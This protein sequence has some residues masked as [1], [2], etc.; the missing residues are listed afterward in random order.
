MTAPCPACRSPHTRLLT[1][2]RD[3]PVHVGSLWRTA[4]EAQ[5]C[6]TGTL[7][8]THCETCQ[9][10]FNSS[11]DSKLMEYT[12]A[13]DNS[14]EASPV[15]RKYAAELAQRLIDDHQLR[16]KR[17]VE[18][19]C[20]KGA[21]ISLLCELGDNR[22]FG[23]DT[24]FDDSAP[25]NP[26]VEF[27]KEHYSERHTAGHADLVCSRHVFE[28]I[29]QPLPF[30]EMV[31][32]SLGD[33]YDTVVYFEVPESLFIFESESIWDLIY[34]H[35]GYFGHESLSGIFARCGFDVLA[36]STT[37]GGQFLGIEA[38]PS[39]NATG[40]LPAIDE[41]AKMG[42][43][44]SRFTDMFEAR[45][46]AWKERIQALRARGKTIAV[47]GAGAKTVSFMNLFQLAADIDAVV[48]INARKQGHF[49]PG[50][51]HAISSP[52]VLR[53]RKPDAVIV[54]NPNYTGEIRA[55]LADIGLS[56]ELLD[57]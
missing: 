14:L 47:W 11:F 56:P 31:R 42:P 18:I 9:Y 30:L 37:F 8:L 45:K 43:H 51:G 34:E 44:A 20:G 28:H 49:L 38:R 24:T 52:E 25:A 17:V 10:V 46:A 3:L 13:Y 26:R 36:L 55:Q 50:T 35:C 33:R 4:G 53:Q 16:G 12:H 40:T 5:T 48:D 22:G 21:F 7:A 23:F 27:I 54:M 1:E 39:R 6:P 41:A 29:P 57:V 19:G 32:R 15:F 2:L